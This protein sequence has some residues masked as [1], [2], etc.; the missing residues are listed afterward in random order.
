M[1]EETWLQEMA[2][3]AEVHLDAAPQQLSAMFSRAVLEEPWLKFEDP[4]GWADDYW[5][6]RFSEDI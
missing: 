4:I 6:G 5:R 3:Y 1:S 2:D